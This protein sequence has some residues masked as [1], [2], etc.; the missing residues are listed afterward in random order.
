MGKCIES[1]GLYGPSGAGK[2]TQT[3]ELASYVRKRFGKDKFVRLISA[4]GGGWSSI[5]A[6]VDLGMVKPLFVRDRLYPFETLKH[7]CNG[8]W[9]LNPEDPTSKLVDPKDQKDFENCLGYVFDSGTEIADWMMSDAVNREAVGEIK[10]SGEAISVK[11]R[12]GQT[13][14]GAP[15]RGHFGA[16]QNN[17]EQAVAWSKGLGGKYVMWTFLELKTADEYGRVIYGPD[18]IGNKKTPKIPAWFEDTIHLYF[19]QDK[20]KGAVRRMYLQRHYEA[21]GIPYDAKTRAP[22]GCPLPEFLEGDDFSIGRFLELMEG[23]QAKAK[24]MLE[25]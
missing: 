6:A 8:K 22:K 7:L 25:G 17:L 14:F 12:D 23:A 16:I 13:M 9:P 10:V 5:Q 18:L 21:D 1:I 20:A 11:F 4:S 2:T 15:G 24:G 19:V 3:Q